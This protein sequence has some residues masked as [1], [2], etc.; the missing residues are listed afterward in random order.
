MLGELHMTWKGVR[1]D[2]YLSVNDPT[3][4]RKTT[5]CTVLCFHK[6][7]TTQIYRGRKQ[8]SRSQV[9]E[10]AARET[11]ASLPQYVGSSHLEY[12]LKLGPL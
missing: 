12:V 2:S 1:A 8:L 5:C 7:Q 3:V 10:C 4:S 6:I 11:W 9:L